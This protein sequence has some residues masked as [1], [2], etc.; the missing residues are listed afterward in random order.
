MTKLH[1]DSQ[2]KDMLG[3][4]LAVDALSDREPVSRGRYPLALDLRCFAD[5]Y[6]RREWIKKPKK[7]S[8]MFPKGEQ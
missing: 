4:S 1:N 3:T 8:C 7:V 6:T 2:P 5:A